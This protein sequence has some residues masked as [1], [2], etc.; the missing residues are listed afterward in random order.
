MPKIREEIMRIHVSF[1]KCGLKPPA[2]IHLASH[3]D[4]EAFLCECNEHA[5][6]VY[7]PGDPAFGAPVEMADGTV[8]MEVQVMGMK[9]RWPA[10]Q[11]KRHRDGAWFYG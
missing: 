1:R 9:V 8:Y 4:G 6:M 10:L 7:Y 2:A 3:E 11:Y 5:R